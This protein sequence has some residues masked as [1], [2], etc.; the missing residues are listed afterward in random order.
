MR[1][2]GIDIITKSEGE[3]NE[4]HIGLGGTMNALF[5]KNLGQ[6]THRGLE[7]RVVSGKSGG[8]R[9]Y[10]YTVDRQPLSDGTWTTGEL[11]ICPNEA[12]VVRRIFTAY[13]SG[14]S[15]R[16]IAVSL[17]SEGILAPR[18]GRGTGT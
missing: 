12:A 1:F 18:S 11:T 4:M 3:I 10:G 2:L 5:L 6:K 7:G 17:N 8:G 14:Q 13:D 9:S 16:A 15:A